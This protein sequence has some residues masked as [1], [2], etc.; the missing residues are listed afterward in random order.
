MKT[1]I[2][3][4]EGYLCGSLLKVRGDAAFEKIYPKSIFEEVWSVLTCYYNE[5]LLFRTTCS[6]QF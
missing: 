3:T 6:S 4:Q 5:H 2:I 1:L